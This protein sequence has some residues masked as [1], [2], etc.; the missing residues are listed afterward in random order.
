MSDSR[1]FDAIELLREVEQDGEALRAVRARHR[2]LK[3]CCLRKVGSAA[4]AAEVLQ[5]A[6]Q[7][8]PEPS[9]RAA[10]QLE[11]ARALERTGP[12]GGGLAGP[13]RDRGPAVVDGAG[14][15][16][17][18]RFR[19][20]STRAL[21]G[22]RGLL[23]AGGAAAA[24]RAHPRAGPHPQH[25]GPHPAASRQDRGG[26]GGVPPRDRALL[27]GGQSHLGGECAAQPR[28][29]GGHLRASPAG[30][31]SVP[32]RP[33]P[34]GEVRGP[35]DG[36]G[37]LHHHRL[38]APVRRAGRRRQGG[39]ATGQR[40]AG[41][42]PA[43]R[44]VPALARDDPR[45]RCPGRGRDRARSQ[46][47]REHPEAQRGGRRPGPGA[48]APGA[49]R[50]RRPARQPRG[51]GGAGRRAAPKGRGAGGRRWRSGWSPRAAGWPGGST[52]RARLAG[53]WSRCRSCRRPCA[54]G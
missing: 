23:P 10:I 40:G 33:A 48:R 2:F 44:A 14:R 16:G 42:R 29:P 12:G 22:G 53:P 43:R 26:T 3:G 8:S 24:G 15:A 11:L 35:A 19:P 13:G 31:R 20:V 41:D 46:R 17:P 6:S 34:G 50:G 7:A 21:R 32:R 36:R 27:S 51:R 28:A 37:A 25:H 9:L 39:D 1:Y 54:A 5:E 49:D 30:P 18:A 4:E 45:V 52:G 47:G 38:H